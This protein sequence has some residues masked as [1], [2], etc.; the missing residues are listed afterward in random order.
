MLLL[1]LIWQGAPIFEFKWTE[2]ER[3]KKKSISIKT[4]DNRSTALK[5]QSEKSETARQYTTRFS[6]RFRVSIFLFRPLS[7]SVSISFSLSP[8]L[9]R[10]PPVYVS[11]CPLSPHFIYQNKKQKWW[12]LADPRY[13]PPPDLIPWA[14][15]VQFTIPPAQL[16]LKLKNLQ[17][18]KRKKGEMCSSATTV[19]T[20]SSS[21]S[22][23]ADGGSKS[24]MASSM[25]K[26]RCLEPATHLVNGAMEKLFFR[27][28]NFI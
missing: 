16:N 26:L 27:F 10:A 18:R 1:F 23:S 24:S 6:T 3:E 13:P 2:G 9:S 20:T 19:S 22:S 17:I 21:S 14:I 5:A 11:N 4:I 15:K 28:A 12:E 25:R 7:L 8:S